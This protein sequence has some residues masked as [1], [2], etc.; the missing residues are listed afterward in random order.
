MGNSVGTPFPL[1]I[2]GLNQDGQSDWGPNERAYL[3]A[4]ITFVSNQVGVSGLDINGNLD[5]GGNALINAAFVQ[6]VLDGDVGDVRTWYTDTNGD[7]WYRDGQGREV[8]VTVGGALAVG[9]SLGGFAGDYVGF[10]P[11]GA[12]YDIGASQFKFTSPAPAGEA[13]ILDVGPVHIRQDTTIFHVGLNAPSGMAGNTELT[14]PGALPGGLAV[15]SI[16][17]T[18]TMGYTNALPISTLI[19]NVS[20]TQTGSFAVV[21]ATRETLHLHRYTLTIPASMAMLDYS[22]SARFNTP[23]VEIA[24]GPLSGSGFPIIYPIPL[25][26]GDRI[27]RWRLYYA[28]NNSTIQSTAQLK[29]Y[30]AASQAGLVAGPVLSTVPGVA[31]TQLTQDV[32]SAANGNIT[33]AQGVQFYLHVNPGGFDTQANVLYHAEVE[34]IRPTGSL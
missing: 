4:L 26:T 20:G 21:Q 7:L 13:A 11:T 15:V 24:L 25:K 31:S 32:S 10:N 17:A 30:V 29:C 14:F 18:G 22:G 2:S 5:M 28:N 8:Q 34:Y 23:G 33:G 19:G 27:Q 9:A 16:D 3:T 12:S 1:P 6:L